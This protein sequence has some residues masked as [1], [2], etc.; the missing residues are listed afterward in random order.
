MAGSAF[1]ATSVGKT[2]TACGGIDVGR[3]GG[4]HTCG[5]LF[6]RRRANAGVSRPAAAADQYPRCAVARRSTSESQLYTRSPFDRCAPMSVTQTERNDVE[7]RLAESGARRARVSSAL[8]P[9]P[10]TPASTTPDCPA[11]APGY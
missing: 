4:A 2:S 8:R 9:T 11:R 5:A 10:S 7:M 6:R 3:R 1:H